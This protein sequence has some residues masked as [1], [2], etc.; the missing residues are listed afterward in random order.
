MWGQGR[1]LVSDIFMYILTGSM[2]SAHTRQW[3]S[4]RSGAGFHV[5]RTLLFESIF[6]K[7]FPVF[8]FHCVWHTPNVLAFMTPSMAGEVI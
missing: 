5:S 8:K 1:D 2:N 6:I 7:I 3:A 4:S